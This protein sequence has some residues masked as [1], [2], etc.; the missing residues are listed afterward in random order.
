MFKTVIAHKRILSSKPELKPLASH[1]QSMAQTNK[2]H[3]YHLISRITSAYLTKSR[4]EIHSLL[5]CDIFSSIQEIQF[6]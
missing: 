4:N 2:A 3:S 6:L 1:F 5:A